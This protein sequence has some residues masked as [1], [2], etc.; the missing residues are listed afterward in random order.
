M[1]MAP[2]LLE[3][4]KSFNFRLTFQVIHFTLAEL[5]TE[6]ELLRAG[7]YQAVDGYVKGIFL[8]KQLTVYQLFTR[9]LTIFGH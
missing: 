6:L 8:Q 9:H 5:A 1:W 2:I 3:G 4:Y 7:L